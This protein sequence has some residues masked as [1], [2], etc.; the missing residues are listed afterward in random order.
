[1]RLTLADLL[2]GTQYVVQ[3]RA[4]NGVAQSAWSPVF[5]LITDEDN[6]LPKIPTNVTWVVVGD[7]FY[8]EWDSMGENVNNDFANIVRYELELIGNSVTKI[9]SVPQITES[10][11]NYTLSFEENKSLFGTAAASVRLRVRSVDIKDLKSGWSTPITVTNAAP[12]APSFANTTSGTGNIQ[13]N[14]GASSS[15]DVV[16]Y[17]VYFGASAGFTPAPGNLIFTGNALTFIFTTTSTSTQYFKIRAVDKF[18]QE[19]TDATVSGTATTPF[20]IDT[21]PPNAPTS[22]VATS[23]GIDTLSQQQSINVSWTASSSTDVGRYEIRYAN[24]TSGPWQVMSVGS[25]QTSARIESLSPGWSYYVAVRAVDYFANE[26][27]WVNAT[28][29]PL[30]PAY[31][32]TPPSKPAVPTAS[33]GM[34]RIQVIA[35]NNKDSGGPMEQ[36]VDYFQVFASTTNGFTP[37][38]ANMLGIIKWGPAKVETFQI[39]A[40]STT[41]SATTETWYVVVKAVDFAG[42][43]SVASNQVT[44]AVGLI[45]TANIADAAITNAK[46]QTLEANKITAGTGIISNLTV[47]STLTLGDVSNTGTIVSNDYVTSSGTAGFYLSNSGLIIKSGLIEAAALNIQDSANLVPAMYADFEGNPTSYSFYNSVAGTTQTI[48]TSGSRY[49]TQHLRNS[50]SSAL[51]SAHFTYMASSSTEY[52]IPV[53]ASTPYLISGW[54]WNTGAVTTTVTLGVAW[55]DSSGAFI[56]NST[57]T[58][59]TATAGT[60]VGSAIRRNGEV[61]SPS[62]AAKA[63]IFITSPTLTANGGYNIDGIQFERKIGASSVPSQWRPPGGT[64]IDGN[65]IRTGEIRSNTTLTINGQTQPT[66]YINTGGAAQFGNLW[67]R[68]SMVVGAAAEDT[69]TGVSQAGASIHSHNYVPNTTGWSILSNGSAEFFNIK[70][71]GDIEASSIKANTIISQ[72]IIAQGTGGIHAYGVRGED[73]GMTGAGFQVLGAYEISVSSVVSTTTNF[74]TFTTDGL[75]GFTDENSVI[76]TG[77]TTWDGTYTITSIPSTSTFTVA[78]TTATFSSTA[79][80]G[81]AQS[82]AT[83]PTVATRPLLIDFPTDGA[84][85][86][87]VSGKLAASTLSVSTATSLQGTTTVENGTINISKGVTDPT[88]AATLAITWDTLTSSYVSTIPAGA[89]ERLGMTIGPDGHYWF[90]EVINKVLSAVKINSATGAL[91]ETRTIATLDDFYG[92]TNNSFGIVYNPVSSRF[93]VGYQRILLNQYQYRISTYDTS[94]NL[95]GD[96]DFSLGTVSIQQ[97]ASSP[98][99]PPYV[100]GYLYAVI[101]WDYT[102]SRLVLAYYYGASGA[103]PAG[104]Q[105]RH[106]PFT[107]TS[108]RPTAMGTN[109]YFGGTDIYTPQQ[110]TH[111]SRTNTIDN[112]VIDLLHLGFSDGQYIVFDSSLFREDGYEWTSPT[113][114]L[115]LWGAAY[116]TTKK[117]IFGF[118]DTGF[119]EYATGEYVWWDTKNAKTKSVHY[120]WFDS[121]ASK[122]AN[123]TGA[124]A[125]STEGTIQLA[126]GHGLVAGDVAV[127][128]NIYV[129]TNYTSV[130]SAK[131]FNGLAKITSSNLAGSPATITYSRSGTAVGLAS[132]TGTVQFGVNETKVSPIASISVP[133]R[134]RI[135]VTVPPIP[136]ATS[137]TVPDK[138]KVYITGQASTA[139]STTINY[140]GVSATIPDSAAV[141]A[142]PNPTYNS[143]A[144]VNFPAEVRSGAEDVSG[145]MI[146]LKGDGGGRV[147][148][149][150][151]D[152]TNKVISAPGTPVTVS[153][154]AQP[155]YSGY[156]PRATNL[157]NNNAWYSTHGADITV[158]PYPARLALVTMEVAAYSVANAQ[159]TWQF[160][161][162]K[163]NSG[164]DTWWL[165]GD[166]VSHNNNEVT[167]SIGA[168]CT[169]LVD[170]GPHQANSKPLKIIV[171]GRNDALSGNWVNVGWLH[172]SI[173]W[174]N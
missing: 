35:S 24:N 12:S 105:Y 29:Y 92:R 133:K 97:S 132:T 159:C 124:S 81:L 1:M 11:N 108:G 50:W 118:I 39:P 25:D 154:Y 122:T 61:T 9:V 145:A 64:T 107:M 22:V 74:I 136:Y 73:V 166:M 67:V 84:K 42:N 82:M 129:T 45:L 70:A 10:R 71:R 121:V 41:P 152:S 85:P 21:T 123:I 170:V 27:A 28:D 76:I 99:G 37:S 172:I 117:Q 98:P 40:S 148:P 83:A 139:W 110:I 5:D 116:N 58:P 59:G 109:D 86:N 137:G 46:I 54:V 26:S 69:G 49:N 112:G 169:M 134:S 23:G 140:P 168:T 161:I 106:V 119:V 32:T 75:H 34:Q 164:T 43:V 104:Q 87:I 163:G 142:F 146:S 47:K 55:A 60:A 53:D 165:G 141:P 66:W 15:D 14:W 138:S 173:T 17:N 135:K 44:A 155:Y 113:G 127:G 77:T 115:A 157:P 30:N 130:A 114:T 158:P 18:G 101:G 57:I 100:V 16:S 31:D 174:M 79:V 120:T 65:L 56:S 128:T 48:N 162:N 93:H 103:F 62:N 20:E 3:V 102:N 94:W 51:G 144:D 63:R 125:T 156:V 90:T 80:K 167:K 153:P 68:G 8:G 151:W 96:N 111:F 91:M 131:R 13:V 150:S 143:F 72:S 126:A 78:F 36:D 88:I 95:I 160:N 2:P 147:G 33:V 7:A 149:L 171:N 52:N 4:D 89:Q 38:N 6:T 19:S